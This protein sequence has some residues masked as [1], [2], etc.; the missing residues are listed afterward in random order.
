MLSIKKETL[1]V[2]HNVWKYNQLRARSNFISF[3]SILIVQNI[4]IQYQISMNTINV[5]L[6]SKNFN[7]Y[8]IRV[9]V[10]S[11]TMHAIC[12]TNCALWI[13]TE[14][15]ICVVHGSQNLTSCAIS[16]CQ[17]RRARNYIVIITYYNWRFCGNQI[18]NAVRNATLH[19]IQIRYKYLRFEYKHAQK[20]VCVSA[21]IHQKFPNIDTIQAFQNITLRKIVNAPPYISNHTLHIDCNLKSL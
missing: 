2:Q 11:R 7:I 9:K 8:V 16:P 19:H 13:C 20:N 21:F 3:I 6:Q 5:I 1:K 17:G 14:K 18:K 15:F 4:I 12:I 10:V